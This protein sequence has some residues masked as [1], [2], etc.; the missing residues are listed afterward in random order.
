MCIVM[1]P[2]ILCRRNI[3]ICG[4]SMEVNC[5]SD[6]EINISLYQISLISA[7]ITEFNIFNK[8]LIIA[9]RPKIVYLDRVISPRYAIAKPDSISIVEYTKDSGVEC[10]DANSEI[11]A[12]TKVVYSEISSVVLN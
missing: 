11:T 9:K 5:I 7:L 8:P 3:L 4:C 12:K 10:T 1:A 2:A 6:I